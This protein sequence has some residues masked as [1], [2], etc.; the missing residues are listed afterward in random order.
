[1]FGIENS[2]WFRFLLVSNRR[3]NQISTATARKVSLVSQNGNVEGFCCLLMICPDYVH[4][5]ATFSDAKL[6]E[7]E[8][9]ALIGTKRKASLL[10]HDEIN[11]VDELG[12]ENPHFPKPFIS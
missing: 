12:V 8:I 11:H 9:R 7:W 4:G 10:G 5:D 6:R 2:F 1:L 3:S